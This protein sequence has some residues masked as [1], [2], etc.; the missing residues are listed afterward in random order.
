MYL[1]FGGYNHEWPVVSV[2]LFGVDCATPIQEFVEDYEE[3]YI[4]NTDF[5]SENKQFN[6]TLGE[7]HLLIVRYLDTKT[8]G[9]ETKDMNYSDTYKEVYGAFVDDLNTPIFEFVGTKPV[10]DEPAPLHAVT[11][12]NDGHICLEDIGGQDNFVVDVIVKVNDKV[13]N[14]D[15]LI[16]T[17]RVKFTN[18]DRQ[19]L[20]IRT[21]DT[22][23]LYGS[24]VNGA[25]LNL[26]VPDPIP[27]MKFTGYQYITP[28]GYKTITY[29]G[30]PESLYYKVDTS[31]FDEVI[32]EEQWIDYYHWEVLFIDGLNNLIEKQ[33]VLNGEAALEPEAEVRDRF[34][35][36]PDDDHCYEFVGWDREFDNI[37]GP[38]VVRAI[39]RIKNK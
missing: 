38:T 29:D 6:H 37:T 8:F 3:T 35:E 36:G 1:L 17:I 32:F 28:L 39:Y 13:T 20:M 24:Y 33:L 30:T 26:P 7:R 9:I 31:V 11:I 25:E 12:S 21:H 14:K 23:Y 27:Y 19:K 16:K 18:N 5:D 34:M 2:P 22:M 10:A 4:S 15:N